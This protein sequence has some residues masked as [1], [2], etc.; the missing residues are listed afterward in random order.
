MKSIKDIYRIG[1]GPSSSHTIAPQRAVKFFLAKYGPCERYEVEF[2]GS[3]ALTGKGHKTDYIVAST[4]APAP[5][6]FVFNTKELHN[7]MILKGYR[8]NEL[9]DEWTILSL[10]GGSVRIDKFVSGDEVDRY[11]ETTFTSFMDSV[12]ASGLSVVDYLYKHEPDLK[13]S[14]KES[15]KVMLDSVKRGLTS[16]GLLN[17]EL[18]Y[19]RCAKVLF[20]KAEDD[21]DRLMAYAYAANEEN[22]AGHLVSTAPTL[23][24]C[25]I[26]ASLMYYQ[27]NDKNVSLDK[28]VDTLAFGAIFGN[29]IKE[30]ASIAG[31]VCGCQAEVGAACSMAAAMVA[32]LKNPNAISVAERAAEIGIEHHLGLTCDPVKGYVI[33]PCIERNANAILRSFDAA[34]LAYKL[35]KIGKKSAITFDMAVKT[36]RITGQKLPIELKETSLGGLAL[37]YDQSQKC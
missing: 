21:R 12:N 33:I 18:D 1:Y 10:G 8:N 22:A 11:P 16:E 34:N 2:R 27:K 24:S 19:Y 35:E 9:V 37:I 15:L 4:L 7:Q 17:K 36:M 28:L 3:L 29:F 25:G 26:V 6:D 5:V 14:L 31:S 20:E 30:N 13:D 32:Y 23:G